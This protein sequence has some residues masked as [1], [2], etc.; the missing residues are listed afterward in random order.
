MLTMLARH[1]SFQ[2][3][4]YMVFVCLLFICFIKDSGI[5]MERTI[6]SVS[7]SSFV[8]FPVQLFVLVK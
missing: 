5:S 8:W 2:R 3:H 4:V 6:C 1:S 7:V